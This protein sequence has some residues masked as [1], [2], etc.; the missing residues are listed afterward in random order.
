[1]F[2]SHSFFAYLTLKKDCSQ[3]CNMLNLDL[4]KLMK[5]KAKKFGR[6]TNF[7]CG[8]FLHQRLPFRSSAIYLVFLC[9][10]VP[11]T[12]KSVITRAR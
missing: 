5:F 12:P 8:L 9:F 11:T 4:F 7:L 3:I 1:M 2:S 6:A 10:S